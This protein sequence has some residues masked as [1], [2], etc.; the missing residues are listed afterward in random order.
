MINSGQTLKALAS[1]FIFCWFGMKMFMKF[2]NP[3]KEKYDS[4][5]I[6]FYAFLV[7]SGVSLYGPG[8]IFIA[9]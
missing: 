1:K 8:V 7:Q 5:L 9:F 6:I 2:Y 3:K 4:V